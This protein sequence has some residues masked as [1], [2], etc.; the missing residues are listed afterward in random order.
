MEGLD[1]PAHRVPVELL[2]RLGTR[3]NWQVGDQFSFDTS[4]P[5]RR[6]ALLCMKD[7][8]LKLRVAALLADWR[9]DSHLLI[10][11]FELRAYRTALRIS[12]LDAMESLDLNMLHGF[13]DRVL[14]I[15]REP[16][17][18]GTH[19]EVGAQIVCGAKQLVDVAFPVADVNAAHGIVEKLSRLPH[20]FQPAPAFLFL[21]R[22]ARGINMTLKLRSPLELLSRPEFHRSQPKWQ[23]IRSDHET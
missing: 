6:I 19:E 9:Q 10:A 23:S 3:A 5:G 16:V 20:I 13:G 2:D 12:K 7:C 15:S 14:P 18:A 1:F 8:E 4:T 11:Q 22:Y 17:D 21:N